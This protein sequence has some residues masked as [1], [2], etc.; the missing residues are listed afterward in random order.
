MADTIRFARYPSAKVF[1]ANGNQ[2]QHLLWGDWVKVLGTAQNGKLP[3]HVRGTDGLMNANDLQTEQL[4]EL[5]FVD[6]GQGDGCLIVTPDDRKLIVDAGEGDNMYRY[7]RWRFNF[8]GGPRRFD[9]A[10]ITHPDSDHY[11]GFKRLFNEANITFRRVYHNG[12]ME[13]NGKPFG[14]EETAG[15]IRYITQLVESRADLEAFLSD[16]ARFGRKL[17][18]NLLKDALA[19]LTA[20]GDVRMISASPDPEQPSYVEGFDAARELRLRVLG[21]IP[22]TGADGRLKLRWFKDQPGRGSYDAGKTKNGHSVLVKVEYRT[23]SILLGG[24]LNASAETF[25]L[26]RYTG[27]PWPP[28]S[29]ASEQTMVEAARRHFEADITKSCHH[30]SADFTDA[31]LQA[32]N[33]AATV[34]SSGDEESHAHPRSDTLGAVGLHGRGWRPLIFSTELARS[35]R[36]DEGERG[37][38]LGRL[39]ERIDRTTDATIRAQLIEQRDALIDELA[40]RNVTTYGAINVRTDGRKALLAYK[41]ERPRIGGSLGSNTQTLTKW[42]IYALEQVGNGPLV[43]V[44]TTR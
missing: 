32:V 8:V 41:L 33:S 44:P 40:S 39:L 37:V 7:L 13:Q 38:A 42:D 28:Q 14:M 26:S 30:G 36:E 22:E 23:L 3:V 17:Y 21:P 19:R 24:D 18:P 15:G 9:A 12:I 29:A 10:I 6:V 5:V 27:L 20:D 31:F 35:S 2:I 25:L 34:I 16:P 4:L 11:S 43:Y 1:D